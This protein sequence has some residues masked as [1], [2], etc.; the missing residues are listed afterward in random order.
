MRSGPRGRY[1][2]GNGLFLL[3]RASARYWLFRYLTRDGR[4]R[5]MGLGLAGEARGE[6]TLAEA[7]KAAKPPWDAVKAGTDP[8]NQRD[9]EA[10]AARAAAQ[11]AAARA[12]AFRTVA[13]HYIAAHEA[14][15]RNPKHR[16]QWRA[17]LE[18]YAYPHMGN[19]PAVDVTTAHV[20]AALKPIWRTKPETATRVRGRIEAVLDYVKVRK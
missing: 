13:E 11:D 2:D 20:L 10:A 1:G 12:I 14:G 9:A 17:T 6:R 8:L 5:E 15:W 7:R 19:L 3:V 18:A 4:M 16:G